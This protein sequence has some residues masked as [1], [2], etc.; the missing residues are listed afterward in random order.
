[1]YTAQIEKQL[2]TARSEIRVPVHARA[3]VARANSCISCIQYVMYNFK[4]RTLISLT[5]ARDNIVA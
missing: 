5:F 1:M 2:K 3:K 4:R